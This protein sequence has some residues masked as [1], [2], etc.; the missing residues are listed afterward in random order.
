M[1]A[2][3][4]AALGNRFVEGVVTVEPGSG[5]LDSRWLVFGASHPLP[6]EASE[7]AGRAALS[8]ARAVRGD[9]E[10]LLVC[11]SGGASAMLAVPAEGLTLE[12]KRA[13]NQV[14]LRAG[15]D[16]GSLNAVR[17]HLSA[18]KGGQLALLA[19][20]SI[21]LA[22]SDVT[23]PVD[24]DPLTIG[25]GPTVGDATTFADALAI[26]DRAGIAESLPAA[27]MRHLAD[28]AACRIDGP[29][30][31]GDIRLRRAS[32]WIVASR[33]DGMRAAAETAR[34]LGYHTRVYEKAIDGEARRAPDLILQA[35]AGVPR[36]ACV[37]CSGETTVRV[38]G[39]GVGGRNQEVAVAAIERLKD[40]APAAL[41]SVGTD[42]IDGPTDAAGALVDSEMW[43]SLGPDARQLC[44]QYLDNNDAY[45]LLEQL[46]GLIKTG[47]TGTNVCDLQVLLLGDV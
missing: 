4:Q 6:N 25:S 39:H 44:D 13:A 20:Q 8:L 16:I 32:Y 2:A 15:L 26:L 40:L 12:D 47:P 23:A 38:T 7:A 45:P 27:V 41:A 17:R 1:A 24:D 18:I 30:K 11:L 31:P 43:S 19:S 22:I 28:G 21:T 33:H 5:E 10:S 34:Q 3:A 46:G 14:M 42:G 37:V 29:P 35:A 9:S 36:P